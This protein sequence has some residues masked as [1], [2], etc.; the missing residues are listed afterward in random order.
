MQGLG[1]WDWGRCCHLVYIQKV[2]SLWIGYVQLWIDVWESVE[3][4]VLLL[5]KWKSHLVAWFGIWVFSIMDLAMSYFAL[6]DV[7]VKT[8]EN[9]TVMMQRMVVLSSFSWFS[10]MNVQVCGII[11]ESIIEL[12]VYA[13]DGLIYGLCASKYGFVCMWFCNMWYLNENCVLIINWR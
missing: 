13:L 7:W 5:S 2:G 1:L 12:T 10:N 8:S 3:W 9:R 6:C 4:G 11:V